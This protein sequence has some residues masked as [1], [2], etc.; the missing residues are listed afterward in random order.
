MSIHLELDSLSVE[1][2][3]SVLSGRPGM[4]KLFYD[5]ED[6]GCNGV[7]VILVVDAPNATDIAV[8]SNSYSF[9]I[10]RQHEQHFDI[11]MRL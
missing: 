10:D 5:T 11:R 8:Q 4:F 3:A 1:R 6:C 7:L 9:W 2:L